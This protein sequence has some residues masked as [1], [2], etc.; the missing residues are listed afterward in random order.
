MLVMPDNIRESLTG[1]LPVNA[2]RS[3][4]LDVVTGMHAG[5]QLV[6]DG[7]ELLVLGSDDDCDIILRDEGVKG[8]HVAFMVRDGSL[9][10]KLLGGSIELNGQTVDHGQLDL[11]GS[12][13]INLTATQI[14]L[15]LSLPNDNDSMTVA[16]TVQ[17]SASASGIQPT[18]LRISM[19]LVLSLVL[20]FALWIFGEAE[21]S[22]GFQQEASI[23]H[24]QMIESILAEL[25]IADELTLSNAGTILTLT[26]VLP[27]TA[28]DD[29]KH[30]LQQSRLAAIMH[31][32]TPEQLLEQVR[33]VFRVNGYKVDL[34]YLSTGRVQ[35]SNLDAR[36][37]KVRAILEHVKQDVPNLAE[38]EF[39]TFVEKTNKLDKASFFIDSSRTLR[40]VVDGETRYVGAQSGARYFTGS[41]LPNGYSIKQIT[42]KGVQ[43][44]KEGERLWLFF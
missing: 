42:S 22:Q 8:R 32:I 33:D 37:P 43:V 15:K 34:E 16:A 2:N 19:V 9:L 27:T 21:I 14:S 35:V 20:L 38:L 6:L 18:T 29:L 41:V 25:D 24:Q 1:D 30:K 4:L 12:D 40:A 36:H 3:W 5:A 7:E 11:S 10:V 44:D 28:L 26:G 39:K 13:T 17:D 23:S 31:I